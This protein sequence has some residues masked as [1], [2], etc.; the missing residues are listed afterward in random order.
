MELDLRQFPSGLFDVAMTPCLLL[1]LFVCLFFQ[2]SS[3]QAAGGKRRGSESGHLTCRGGDLLEER[4]GSTSGTGVSRTPPGS[5]F[6]S[7]C[8]SDE[9]VDTLGEG[10]FGKVVRCLDHHR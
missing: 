6:S 9:I 5:N 2:H 10:T 1:Y 7:V 4:C 8:S 3:D